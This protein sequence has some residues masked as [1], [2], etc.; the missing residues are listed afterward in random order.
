MTFAY[1]FLKCRYFDDT[2]CTSVFTSICS[3]WTLHSPLVSFKFLQVFLLF[4]PFALICAYIF[5]KFHVFWRKVFFVIFSCCFVRFVLFFNYVA[6]IALSFCLLIRL[7]AASL[8]ASLHPFVPT[9]RFMAFDP[10]S[11][12]E[13]TDQLTKVML[14]CLWTHLFDLK[15]NAVGFLQAQA[16]KVA[17]CVTNKCM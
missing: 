15:L 9:L 6:F 13:P 11:V 7:L 8:A 2:H 17:A 16:R 4:S 14:N 12:V 5:M 10:V 1:L 3:L